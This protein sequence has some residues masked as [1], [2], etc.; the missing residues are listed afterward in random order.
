[1]SLVRMKYP[2]TNQEAALT[3]IKTTPQL[4]LAKRIRRMVP[5]IQVQ[6]LRTK[7]KAPILLLAQILPIR[8]SFKMIPS[9]LSKESFQ[10]LKKVLT[11]LDTHTIRIQLPK[12]SQQY[13]RS[14]LSTYS[15][16]LVL[17]YLASLVKM[18]STRTKS[19]YFSIRI[20][21]TQTT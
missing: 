3:Q 17:S 10:R 13:R 21:N 15:D 20:S 12:R 9:K 7:A 19:G 16:G 1:M 6:L 2:R 5:R 4:I 11:C 18:N 8:I 14:I